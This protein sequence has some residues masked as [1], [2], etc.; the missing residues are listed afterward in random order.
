MCE[1]FMRKNFKIYWKTLNNILIKIEWWY[2]MPVDK[3]TKY[4]KKQEHKGNANISKNTQLFS[5]L[6]NVRWNHNGTPLN[7]CHTDKNVP[8][9]WEQY[10]TPGLDWHTHFVVDYHWLL[11][12]GLVF[13]TLWLRGMMLPMGSWPR[14]GK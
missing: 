2:M 7:L 6:G 8:Y 11:A 3:K 5:N 1:S 12:W 13:I 10:W 4:H 14:R 9:V